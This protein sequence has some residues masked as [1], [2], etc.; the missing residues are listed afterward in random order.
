MAGIGR[1]GRA[2]APAG[3]LGRINSGP[4]PFRRGANFV[5]LIFDPA[6]L[7]FRVTIAPHTMKIRPKHFPGHVDPAWITLDEVL[8]LE[9]SGWTFGVRLPDG[10][11]WTQPGLRVLG[12]REFVTIRECMADDAGTWEGACLVALAPCVEICEK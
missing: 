12:A 4:N 7:L 6:G 2:H 5:Y 8:D 1:A 9:A 10:R 3:Q 11:G